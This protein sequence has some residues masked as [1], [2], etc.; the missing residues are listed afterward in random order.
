MGL[1]H[2]KMRLILLR[3]TVFEGSVWKLGQSLG[4]WPLERPLVTRSEIDKLQQM[5]SHFR[6]AWH[7]CLFLW[8]NFPRR[9]GD[10]ADDEEKWICRKVGTRTWCQT[11]VREDYCS[12]R[13]NPLGRFHLTPILDGSQRAKFL[14]IHTAEDTLWLSVTN[15]Q[16]QDLSFSMWEE[17]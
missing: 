13:C 17:Y 16:C 15:P 9:K 1:C 11:C 10:R 14:H 2:K 8:R 6:L 4:G 12:P 3:I 7:S 5:C